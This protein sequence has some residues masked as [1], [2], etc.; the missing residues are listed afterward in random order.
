MDERAPQS[1]QHI[2]REMKVA[3]AK[4]KPIEKVVFSQ[5]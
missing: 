3:E 1:A 4:F 2:E 5:A